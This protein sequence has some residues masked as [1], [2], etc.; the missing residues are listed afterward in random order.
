M[1][2]EAVRRER[3]PV[4]GLHVEGA[5]DDEERDDRELQ[6]HHRGV[7]PGALADAAH[8]HP[9]DRKATMRKAGRLKMS[10][11]AEQVRRVR[12][13]L[14]RAEDAARQ[15]R[16]PSPAGLRRRPGARGLGRACGSRCRARRA[17]SRP[18]PAQQLLEVA[19]PRDGDGDVADG[20]LDDQVP[21]DDPRDQL[22]ERGVGVGVGRSG[23]RHH[24][25][26]LGVAER[27]EAAGDGREHEREHERRAGAEV[28]G[29][30]GRRRADRREDAGADDRADAERG[31]LH[32][33]ERPLE[34]L[35]SALRVANQPVERLDAKDV[36]HGIWS[37]ALA[38]IH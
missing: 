13:G 27:R 3:R 34:L 11:H 22:A 23:D 18:K 7:E 9:R 21:A 14:R 6:D 30:A 20:V 8:Q 32:R 4:L 36:G 16:R 17:M 15:A 1:P 28:V 5:D 24:R 38:R 33:T 12:R 26:E 37:H 25:R 19:R 2:R 29:A 10:G 35:V 31:E